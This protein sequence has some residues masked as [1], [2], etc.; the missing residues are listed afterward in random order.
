[1][2]QTMMEVFLIIS[3]D[4]E[5]IMKYSN[6]SLVQIY[7]LQPPM[8]NMQSARRNRNWSCNVEH[9]KG[10][11]K[12]KVYHLRWNSKKKI[13]IKNH[14]PGKNTMMNQGLNSTIAI[15]LPKGHP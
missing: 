2:H 8:Y 10:K 1:M 14:K 7:K 5:H 6:P 3:K 11:T 4:E 12:E 9:R 15:Q 13:K